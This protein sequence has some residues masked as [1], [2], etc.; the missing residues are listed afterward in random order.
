MN[1]QALLDEITGEVRALPVRGD[2]AHYI[3]EL[4]RVDP[5]QFGIALRRQ[6]GA[7]FGAGDWQTRFSLQSMAKV[8]LLALACSLDND[9]VWSRVGVEPSGDPFNSLVQLEFERTRTA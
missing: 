7:T 8:L 2:V 9:R 3:P 1:Y 4:A 5:N 6:D